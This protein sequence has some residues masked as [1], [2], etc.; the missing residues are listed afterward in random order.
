MRVRCGMKYAAVLLVLVIIFTGCVDVKAYDKQ[1]AEKDAV[2]AQLQRELESS[3]AEMTAKDARMAGL[4]AELKKA[5]I[6]L[7]VAL[8]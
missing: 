4:E 3:R 1:L 2:I 8:L 6:Y 7:R 5:G